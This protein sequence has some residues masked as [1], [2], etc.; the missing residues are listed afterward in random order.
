MSHVQTTKKF[1][2]NFQIIGNYDRL[3]HKFYNSQI[4]YLISKRNKTTTRKPELFLLV[5]NSDHTKE[6]ISSL[7]PTNYD[8]VFKFERSQARYKL[9][10]SDTSAQIVSDS[11]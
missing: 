11:K 10:L 5:L 8:N 4:T 6:Y 1:D 2:T 9:I 3:G 7:Y